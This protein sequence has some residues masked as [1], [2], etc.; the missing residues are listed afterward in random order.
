MDLSNRAAALL[1]QEISVKEGKSLI[2]E[3]DCFKGF[4]GEEALEEMYMTNMEF[5]K[6]YRGICDEYCQIMKTNTTKEVLEVQREAESTFDAAIKHTKEK[7][8]ILKKTTHIFSNCGQIAQDLR[9]DQISIEEASNKRTEIQEQAKMMIYDSKYLSFA[10]K[11]RLHEQVETALKFDAHKP[12]FYSEIIAQTKQEITTM[13]NKHIDLEEN[14]SSMRK[15]FEKTK[16]YLQSQK[17]PLGM[18]MIS[19]VGESVQS[20]S[21]AINKFASKDPK[22]IISGIMDVAAAISNFLPPPANAIMGPISTIFGG[23]F[24]M[25]TTSP[26]EMIKDELQKL[27]NY[28]Q[29]EFA[30]VEEGLK[31]V[32]LEARNNAITELLGDLTN[33][34][35]FLNGLEDYVQPLENMALNEVEIQAFVGQVNDAFLSPDS[36]QGAKTMTY[37]DE[38]CTGKWL[39][40]TDSSKVMLP[41]ADLVYVYSKMY[42]LRNVLFARFIVLIRASPLS[43][44]TESNLRV[45]R[46]MTEE[47]RRFLTTYLSSASNHGSAPALGCL[48]NGHSAQL[49]CFRGGIVSKLEQDKIDFFDYLKKNL[50]ED[51]SFTF[52]ECKQHDCREYLIYM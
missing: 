28:L 11:A 34:I 13:Q 25:G 42:V 47:I 19:K 14:M 17:G 26:Q 50:F 3:A 33:M 38:Y 2:A 4:K 46:L 32:I 5:S 22:Q 7:E 49:H 44:L 52:A 45:R 31:K 1:C 30:K 6:K 37:L 12:T 15:N 43:R 16:L 8:D 48:A 36:F 40:E 21:S 27:K 51:S 24:S 41:C 39:K 29:K 23:L 9:D 35:Q 20:I 10:E 18:N